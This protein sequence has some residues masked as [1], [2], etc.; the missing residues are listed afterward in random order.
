M[1]SITMLRT[2]VRRL[3]LMG[4]V[5]QRSGYTMQRNRSNHPTVQYGS[6]NA[7]VVWA[8]PAVDLCQ[9]KTWSAATSLVMGS[10]R[11]MLLVGPPEK[12]VHGAHSSRTNGPCK[13]VWLHM[14]TVQ[15][16]SPCS[17][18]AKAQVRLPMVQW[19]RAENDRVRGVRRE[20]RLVA[21]CTSV[22]PAAF[23]GAVCDRCSPA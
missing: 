15:P 1:V 12:Q 18:D 21:A 8:T 14:Q 5:Q 6:L 16:P 10:G 3:G 17:L 23:A 13:Q 22:Q 2:G 20:S 7:Y 19:Q 9:C 4:Y 11:H